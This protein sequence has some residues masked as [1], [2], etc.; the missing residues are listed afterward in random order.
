MSALLEMLSNHRTTAPSTAGVPAELLSH[1]HC[2]Y[3]GFKLDVDSEGAR[4]DRIVYGFLRCACCEYPVVDGIPILRQMEGL[5]RVVRLIGEREFRWALLR[6]LDL[7]RTPWASQNRWRRLL[8]HCACSRVTSGGNWTFDD[9]VH[10]LRRPG[11]FADYLVHRY[12]NPSF[13]AAIGPLLLLKHAAAGE[14]HGD[15]RI[16]DLACG[17]GHA[18]F[19]IGL[20]FPEFSVI[21]AD[22]D[23]LNLYLARRYMTPGGLQVCIDAQAPS[24][25]PDDYYRAVYCQDAFH[26]I[27][28]KKAVVRELKRVLRA[29]ALW[30]FP[31]LHNRLSRN[32]VPGVPL[33]PEGYL[34]CFDLA[35]GRLFVESD[36]LQGLVREGFVDFGATASASRLDDAPAL[37][38]IRGGPDLWSGCKDFPGRFCERKEHLQVNP[39]YRRASH[40]QCIELRWP[41]ATLRAECAAVEAYL[42]ETCD[43]TSEQWVHFQRGGGTPEWL[44]EMVAKFVLVPLPRSYYRAG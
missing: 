11:V 18:S 19:L 41:N 15:A 7:F 34:K 16:L 43:L 20:L 17:A 26:Y 2:P 8:H 6:T 22:V 32:L 40:G 21:S 29:D 1:L 14:M 23:F 5:E 38:F 44:A 25:F 28:S 42:P 12:A 3:C 24:P 10:R 27:G 30:I 36:L 39:I 35:D 13:L 33:S 4:P 31:H 37:T 9:A